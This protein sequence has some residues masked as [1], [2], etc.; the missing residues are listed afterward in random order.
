MSAIL[1]VFA[2]SDVHLATEYSLSWMSGEQV[3]TNA[4]GLSMAL[5]GDSVK[6]WFDP[7]GAM[8]L[9]MYVIV[10]WALT[11]KEHLRML[12]AESAPTEL[13]Q[14]IT[15]IA[16]KSNCDRVDKERY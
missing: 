14:K 5:L 7:A 11:C 2:S 9:S 3:L 6:Y 4:L 10:T 13:L 8:L 15:F 12:T 1:G 16:S